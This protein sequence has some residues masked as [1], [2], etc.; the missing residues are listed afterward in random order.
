MAIIIFQLAVLIFSVIIHELAHGAIALKLGDRTA[1][2]AGRLTLNPLKHLD[3]I[4]SLLLPLFLYIIGGPVFGWAKP[5]PYNPYN[6]KNPKVG[7]GIIAAAGPL[8]NI[9][10]AL[11]FGIFFRLLQP[12]SNMELIA[13]LLTL[14]SMIVIINISLAIFNLLPLPPL[15]GSN[16]LFAFLPD[17]WQAAQRFLSCY[18][19]YILFFLIIFQGLNFIIP[20]ITF[21]YSLFTG[22]TV[23]V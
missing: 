5:V 11:V 3:P 16:I 19:F 17:S 2:E 18:G 6:L 9:L 7:G 23:S 15:D 8:S 12:W 10:L 21:I 14:F 4:G 20:A 13:I 22:D 1:K